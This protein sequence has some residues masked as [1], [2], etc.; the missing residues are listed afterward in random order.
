[1]NYQRVD[2]LKSIRTELLH[3]INAIEDV[4]QEEKEEYSL[5]PEQVQLSK[6]GDTMQLYLSYMEEAIFSIKSARIF[7]QEIIE[8][9]ETE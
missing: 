1:M 2:K 4:R 7:L 9:G 3:L 8:E 6:N 5:L